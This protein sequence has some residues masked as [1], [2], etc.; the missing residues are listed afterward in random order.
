MSE[1]KSWVE[2]TIRRTALSVFNTLRPAWTKCNELVLN[3]NTV[4]DA[5][6]QESLRGETHWRGKKSDRAKHDD[7][8]GYASL[9]YWYI[10]KIARVVRPGPGDTVY[11]LGCGLGRILCVMARRAVRR[12]VGVE[13][14][15]SLCKLA[16]DNARRL[17]GRRTEIEILCEDCA[18]ADLGNGTI[19]VMFNPFGPETLRDV[20]ENIGGSL[21]NHPRSVQIVYYNAVHEDLM[22]SA[23]W[24]EPFHAFH[25]ASGLRV[26][27]WRSRQATAGCDE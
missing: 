4:L 13:L 9:D 3:I 8:R 18:K 16:R 1:S 21:S 22:K 6:V 15:E 7:N 5:D 20:L 27:F 26:S 12:C 10:W 24:L 23:G 2:R 17:R 11:D 14:V 19:Y 25:T